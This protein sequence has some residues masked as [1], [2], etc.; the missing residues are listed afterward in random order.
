MNLVKYHHFLMITFQYITNGQQ[1]V[2]NKKSISLLDQKNAF[3]NNEV[4]S[5]YI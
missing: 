2:R 5:E 4:L 3:L 1:F